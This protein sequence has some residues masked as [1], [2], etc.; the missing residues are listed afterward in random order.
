MVADRYGFLP[1]R[2]SMTSECLARHADFLTIGRSFS[3]FG[4]RVA[5]QGFLGLSESQTLLFFSLF[6]HVSA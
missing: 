1:I 3:G 4:G 5:F 2:L 6:N